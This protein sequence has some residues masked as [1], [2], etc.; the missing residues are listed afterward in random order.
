MKSKNQLERELVGVVASHETI[1]SMAA[2]N[3]RDLTSDEQSTILALESQAETLK[4]QIEKRGEIETKASRIMN[5]LSDDSVGKVPAKAITKSTTLFASNKDAY[6]S[7]R[8]LQATLLG[9]PKAH[10]YCREQG[11]IQNA[12]TGGVNTAGGFLVPDKLENTIIE[13]RESYGVFRQNAQTITM[14][15]STADIPK[16]GSELTSYFVGENT[17]ITKSDMALNLVRLDAKKLATL[18]VISSELDEDSVISVAEMLARSVS[19]VFAVK[20]DACGFIGDGTSTYGGMVGLENALA[21]GSVQTCT[22]HATF[23]ALTMADFEGTI[24]KAKVWAGSRPKWF[25]SQAGYVNSMLRLQ[26]AAGGNNRQDL[27]AGVPPSFMGYPVIVS[28]HLE[29]DLSGTS[30]LPFAYFGDLMQGVYLGTRRGVSLAIDSSRYFE[31]DA[32]AIR[33]T[34]RFD[35]VCHDVGTASVSGGIIKMIFG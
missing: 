20:E 3:N 27:A 18:T 34:E 9:D 7:G 10:A 2:E 25:I 12:M 22:G 15:D 5:S 8:W 32:L 14:T 13:L 35:I 1:T 31:N 19:Q 30:G 11:M 24:G 17:E 4:A 26:N 29:S 6:D 33:A 16:V 28:Q 21:A 23:S